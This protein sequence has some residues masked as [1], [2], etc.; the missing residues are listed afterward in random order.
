MEKM[1][2]V[3]ES[4]KTMLD[5]TLTEINNH[6]DKDHQLTMIELTKILAFNSNGSGVL[7][8]KMPVVIIQDKNKRGRPNK[9][10]L[11]R[12]VNINLED[13]PR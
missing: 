1:L 4:F 12:F 2:R 11:Q 3:H 6:A 7:A 5:K 13:Y 10:L 9:P 8:I